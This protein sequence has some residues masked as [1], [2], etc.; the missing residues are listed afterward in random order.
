[1]D[2][3]HRGTLH[4]IR[5]D[6]AHGVNRGVRSMLVDGVAHPADA[7]GALLPLFDDGARHR[8]DIILG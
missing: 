2:Y 3:L 5:V 1:M 6:N 4:S 8:I 7:E